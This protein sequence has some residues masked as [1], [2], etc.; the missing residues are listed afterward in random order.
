MALNSTEA[1]E[2]ERVNEHPGDALRTRGGPADGRL[3]VPRLPG[4]RA[5]DD[6]LEAGIRI[7]HINKVFT[8]RSRS[9]EALRD[10]SLDI[11]RGSFLVLIGPSGCGKSTLLRILGDLEPPHRGRSAS[12]MRRPR[13]PAGGTT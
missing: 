7:E 11:P 4:G 6:V 1:R 10:V 3:G 12:T 8:T 13:L 5:D 2:A 9:V